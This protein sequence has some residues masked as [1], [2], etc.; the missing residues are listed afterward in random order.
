[1]LIR[2]QDHQNKRSQ[3]NNL[4][5]SGRRVFSMRY[6]PASLAIFLTTALLAF[7]PSAGVQAQDAPRPP[8]G[9]F[10]GV[11]GGSGND[12][13]QQPA[14]AEDTELVDRLGRIEQQMRQMTG[15]IEELQFHNKQLQQQIQRM[16]EDNE[17]RFQ[18]LGG[19]HGAGAPR[20]PS[21]AAAP[22]GRRSEAKE[23]QY[24]GRQPTDTPPPRGGAENYQ[25]QPYSGGQQAAGNQQPYE[26]QRQQGR[27]SDVFDPR[28]HPNA[29]GAPRALG[30]GGPVA[31]AD[32]GSSIGAR[33][34]RDAGQ[35]LDLSTVN[36]PDGDAG[37]S[38]GYGSTA[39]S[40]GSYG[41]TNSLPP[42][43]ARN[44]SATGQRVATLPPSGSP[45]D[46]LDLGVGYVEHKDYARAETA[47]NGFLQRFPKNALAPDARYW[48]G[49]SLFQ[50]Q[51]YRDAAEQFLT[52]T[53]KY[54][55]SGKAPDALMRLGQA[56]KALGE[57]DTAC[58][59]WGEVKRKYPRASVSVRQGVAR[60]LKRA[61]C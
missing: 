9:L 33:G 60:E 19:G 29:P 52:V 54:D 47:L 15:S 61:H 25:Q 38:G 43:P 48:L 16:Q 2:D 40:G 23:P 7:A 12:R 49:E 13:A 56:L 59:A 37:G 39:P 22:S 42:P 11:F 1:M 32:P 6:A 14:Q 35:P 41:T 51:Q 31:S 8:G 44:P 20:S 10:G 24:A 18:Q 57:K 4:V 58:A 50:R 53:T 3:M 28:A 26:D 17:Y 55:T 30:G 27:R 5:F 45:K 34:G 46:Q 21:P 36:G